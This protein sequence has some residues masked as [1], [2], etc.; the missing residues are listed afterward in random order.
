VVTNPDR[1]LSETTDVVVTSDSAVL[2][3]A[4]AWLNLAAMALDA[5]PACWLLALDESIAAN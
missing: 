4:G 5:E 1:V 2:D 3:C